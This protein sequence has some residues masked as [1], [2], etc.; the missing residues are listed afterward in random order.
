NMKVGIFRISNTIRWLFIQLDTLKSRLF[1]EPQES[2]FISWVYPSSQRAD[3]IDKLEILFENISS[4]DLNSWLLNRR[5]RN[6]ELLELV[7]NENGFMSLVNDTID[8]YDRIR[9]GLNYMYNSSVFL[10]C[11]QE[12]MQNLKI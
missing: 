4:E 2:G 1:S 12:R 7:L 3:I 5:K 6:D 11:I 10:S 8:G 9:M